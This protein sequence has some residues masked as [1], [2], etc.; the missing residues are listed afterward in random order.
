MDSY[1][2][3]GSEELRSGGSNLKSVEVEEVEEGFSVIVRDFSESDC[4]L[5]AG[6]E[7]YRVFI[8]VD[9]S[10]FEHTQERELG[11]SVVVRLHSNVFV[12]PVNR[13]SHGTEGLTHLFDVFDSELTAHS[14]ELFTADIVFGDVVNLFD[15]DFSRETVTVPA[16]REHDVESGHAFIAGDDI[17]IDPV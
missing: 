15:F 6:T 9:V 7:V 3:T 17:H 8:L 2:D 1:S 13:E 14:S 12:A 5:T 10:V 4:R 16:L 11:L